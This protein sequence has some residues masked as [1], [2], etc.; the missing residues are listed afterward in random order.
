MD[1]SDLQL[2]YILLTE[3]NITYAA[4]KMNLSQPAATIRLG[5]M[6]KRFNDELLMRQGNTMIL[7]EKATTI[8]QPLK[9]LLEQINALFP[10]PHFDP[11]AEPC[12]INIH[13]NEYCEYLMSKAIINSIHSFHPKHEVH[14][15]TFP[16]LHHLE[17]IHN[18]TNAEIVIGALNDSDIPEFE[19]ETSHYDPICLVYNEYPIDKSKELTLSEYYDLPHILTNIIEND[20]PFLQAL[21]LPDP[22]NVKMRVLSIK[23]AIS[24]LEDKF[25]MTS[26]KSLAENFQLKTHSL[27]INAPP[28]ACKMHYPERLKFDA[29]NKW[30]RSICKNELTKLAQSFNL[31][32]N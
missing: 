25:V 29:K 2:L 28:T 26:L 9:R 14:L 5:K 15:H 21:G 31:K 3:R 16:P 11:K 1:I 24:L 7:T 20:N 6:R 30:L 13:M 18:F 27:P 17:G 8:I 32:I 23:V 22:R 19:S 12:I 4:E 10:H